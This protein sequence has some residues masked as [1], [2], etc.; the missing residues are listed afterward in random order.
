MR[1]ADKVTDPF[2]SLFI[3]FSTTHLVVWF[4]QHFLHTPLIYSYHTTDIFPQIPTSSFHA[5]LLQISLKPKVLI[6]ARLES[7]LVRG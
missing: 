7:M 2:L 3:V 6:N 5:V 4:H 1:T